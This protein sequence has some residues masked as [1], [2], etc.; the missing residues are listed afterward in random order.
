MMQLLLVLVELVL[1]LHTVFQML[2]LKQQ[3]LQNYFQHV[4]IQL[5]LKVVLMQH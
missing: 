2:V 3:L 4:V 5:P 1:E